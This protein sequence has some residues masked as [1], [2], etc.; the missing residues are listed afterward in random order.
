M[1]KITEYILEKLH[2][3]QFKKDEHDLDAFMDKDFPR[4]TS[5]KEGKEYLWFKW[6]KYLC[7]NGPTSKRDLLIEFKLQPTSYATMFAKLS[8][9]NII[10]PEKGKLVAKKVSEWKV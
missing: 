6:W 4:A 10:T 8:K 5:T 3:S 7:I 2:V 1:K 9:E